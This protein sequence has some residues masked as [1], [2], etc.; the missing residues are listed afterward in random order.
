[1][2]KITNNSISRYPLPDGGYFEYDIDYFAKILYGRIFASN[3]KKIATA[4]QAIWPWTKL[5]SPEE[6]YRKTK[7]KIIS[8]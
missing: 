4:R 8:R 2:M 6:M 7:D 5:L 3:G 1:M